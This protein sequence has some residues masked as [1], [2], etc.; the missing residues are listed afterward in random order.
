MA[1]QW[2]RALRLSAPPR[3]VADCL[4]RAAL[5]R[6]R[7]KPSM[8]SPSEG[9]SQEG[10]GMEAPPLSELPGQLRTWRLRLSCLGVGVKVRGTG[11]TQ[12]HVTPKKLGAGTRKREICTL[13]Q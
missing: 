13:E 12:A 5:G 9:Q 8:E 3:L 7:Q 2:P 4:L 10:H 11:R 1:A 6:S